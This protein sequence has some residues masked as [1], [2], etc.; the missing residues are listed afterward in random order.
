MNFRA[1]LPYLFSVLLVVACVN[2][3][4]EPPPMN[5]GPTSTA[6]RQELIALKLLNTDGTPAGG[7]TDFT[8]ALTVNGATTSGVRLEVNSGELAVREGDDSNYG[9]LQA[10]LITVD[11]SLGGT[12]GVRLLQSGGGTFASFDANNGLTGGSGFVIAWSNSSNVSGHSVGLQFAEAGM[13][14]VNDGAGTASAD[15]RDLKVR[16]LYGDEQSDPAAPAANSGVLYF[17]DNGSGKTQLVVR[18]P[19]GAVQVIATEP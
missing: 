1:I 11:T 5:P 8:P 9:P 14:A 3:R 19:T 13:V 6:I 4:A 16:G 10:K 15:L 17:R 12:S 7:G 2:V 18:F